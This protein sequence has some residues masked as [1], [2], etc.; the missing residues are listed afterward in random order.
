MVHAESGGGA[1]R[2]HDDSQPDAEAE[3][4]SNAQGELAKLQTEQQNGD[5][6][7]TRDQPACE[8]EGD[9]QA[10]G[11]I[12]ICKAAADSGGV[13]ALMSILEARC[14]DIQARWWWSWSL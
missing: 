9:D 7:R 14:A 4:Q 10:G 6:R 2:D 11:D 5:C 8:P 12:A 13:L 1:C 3:H